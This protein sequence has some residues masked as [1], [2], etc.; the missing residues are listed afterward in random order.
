MKSRS[1]WYV[2]VTLPSGVRHHLSGFKTE[3]ERPGCGLRSNRAAWLKEYENGKY[4]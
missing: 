1:G 4:A 3:Q 2:R